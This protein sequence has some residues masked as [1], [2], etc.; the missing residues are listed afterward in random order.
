MG[1][2]RMSRRCLVGRWTLPKTKTCWRARVRGAR[3][4]R[5]G[6]LFHPHRLARAVVRHLACQSLDPLPFLRAR[7]ALGQVGHHV[8]HQRPSRTSRT[9][10][11]NPMTIH[12]SAPVDNEKVHNTEDGAEQHFDIVACPER[13]MTAAM[14]RGDRVESTDGPIDHVRITCANRHWFLMPADTLNKR[15]QNR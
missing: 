7:R 12:N 5:R 11:R 13:S 15:P 8:S 6:N 14:Q 10:E 2:Q 4:L 1:T 3:V 9:V